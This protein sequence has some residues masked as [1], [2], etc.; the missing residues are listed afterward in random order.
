[1]GLVVFYSF[2][3]EILFEWNEWYPSTSI[4]FD[5]DVSQTNSSFMCLYHRFFNQIMHVNRLCD[6]VIVNFVFLYFKENINR[7]TVWTMTGWNFWET[8]K[9]IWYLLF[10]LGDFQ[11]TWIKID[12]FSCLDGWNFHSLG[13]KVRPSTV[14]SIMIFAFKVSGII[15]S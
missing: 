4:S 8:Y 7:L 9:K 6:L 10:S 2:H 13:V 5:A 3:I 11:R 15:S 1:M 14:I 12:D